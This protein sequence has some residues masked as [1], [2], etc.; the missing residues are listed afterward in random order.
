MI[1]A[2]DND[3]ARIEGM[4]YE[5]MLRLWRTAPAGH[6]YFVTGTAIERAFSARM[7]RLREQVGDAGHTAASK[8]IG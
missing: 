2:I 5:D 8:R 7:K 6:P 3:L 4:T 1:D